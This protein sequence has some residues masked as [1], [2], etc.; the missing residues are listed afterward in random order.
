M[1]YCN[2]IQRK[3]I[4]YR[5]VEEDVERKT[6]RYDDDGEDDENLYQCLHDLQEH[7]H[8]DTKEVKPGGRDKYRL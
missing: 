5:I 2:N 7:H 3:T 6:E 4:I 1:F 8:V